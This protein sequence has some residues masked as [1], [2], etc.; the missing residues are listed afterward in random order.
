MGT[1]ELFL[2]E[3]RR[4]HDGLDKH[5][6]YDFLGVRPGSD[7]VAV[8]DAFHARAQRCH[9][10]R[11]VTAAETERKIAYEVYKRMTE[12]YA[13]LSDPELRSAY[14][15][16][17]VTGQVRLAET[18]RARRLTSEERQVS[19]I[20]ARIYLRSARAKIARADV[21][22]A[23]IDVELGLDLEA[24][25]PLRAL[26]DSVLAHPRARELLGGTP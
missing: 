5:N 15:A 6:Y 3:I 8:R 25:E 22:G 23:W 2:E 13:V 16:V 26:R 12:A 10:D 24:A 19:N 14:D 1:A 4:L 7:Y 18:A 11:F 21:L 20:F 17:R 9:P